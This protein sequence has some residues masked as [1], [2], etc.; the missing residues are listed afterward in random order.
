[1]LT[2][3]YRN[4]FQVVPVWN[5][6]GTYH[7]HNVHN[8]GWFPDHSE[9]FLFQLCNLRTV[10]SYWGTVHS[11]S[12]CQA[13]DCTM[14]R[15]HT[16]YLNYRPSDYLNADVPQYPPA[17]PDYIKF[18]LL[19]EN[20]ALQGHSVLMPLKYNRFPRKY[21]HFP[22]SIYYPVLRKF[23]PNTAAQSDTYRC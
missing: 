11:W 2:N 21:V 6:K 9:A 10:C 3:H 20:N 19:S 1:M 4:P 18:L 17:I 7:H 13:S 14:L 16:I 12:G 15:V 22:R 5:D 23:L 8:R